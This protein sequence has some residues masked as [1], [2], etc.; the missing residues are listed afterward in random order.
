MES[1]ICMLCSNNLTKEEEIFH[2]CECNMKYCFYC[3]RDLFEKM[4]GSRQGA[5]PQCMLPL[6]ARIKVPEVPMLRK[7]D[8]SNRS[9]LRQIRVLDRKSLYLQNI[10]SS[11]SVPA[12]QS[13]R[14]LGKYGQI[15]G[16]SIDLK[17]FPK[18]L[19]E[20]YR[21][22]IHFADQASAQKAS[23]GLNGFKI[24]HNQLNAECVSTSFCE[25][26]IKGKLCNIRNCKFLHEVPTRCEWFT[27]KELAENPQLTSLKDLENYEV[28][29]DKDG[30]FPSV[31]LVRSS[32]MLGDILVPK[33]S[34]KYKPKYIPVS[35][36]MF[37]QEIVVSNSVTAPKNISITEYSAKL[38]HNQNKTTRGGVF[39]LLSEEDNTL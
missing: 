27:A 4:N 25:N 35:N 9:S 29:H 32:S 13:E 21:I 1:Q 19:P 18:D 22:F 2:P 23:V 12:L 33:R 30:G 16:I 10:P 31:H 24:A 8:A 34:N 38:K 6:K 11:L 37:Q 14:F 15:L 3:F 28:I 36:L 26:F 5:C 39:H 7:L 17:Y 20:T